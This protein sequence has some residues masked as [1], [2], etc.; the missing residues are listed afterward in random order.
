MHTRHI[1]TEQM[2]CGMYDRSI[3]RA[4]P[5]RSLNDKCNAKAKQTKRWLLSTHTNNA[6]CESDGG[7]QNGKN[8]HFHSIN[9]LF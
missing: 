4:K 2:E 5:S 8:T 1:A 6:M 7:G 9:I 3:Q